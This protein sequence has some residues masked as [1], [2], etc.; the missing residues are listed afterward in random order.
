MPDGLPLQMGATGSDIWGWPPASAPPLLQWAAPTP[1]FHAPH[2][3]PH[4]HHHH[5]APLLLQSGDEAVDEEDAVSAEWLCTV[6]TGLLHDARYLHVL[7]TRRAPLRR[8]CLCYST[9]THTHTHTTFTGVHLQEASLEWRRLHCRCR[10]WTILT[11]PCYLVGCWARLRRGGIWTKLTTGY[12]FVAVNPLSLSSSL[13]RS[14]RRR[15]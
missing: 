6:L 3:H 7:C 15:R 13:M 10:N 12:M 4:H 8:E 11:Q 5:H 14:S 2:P 1:G 9:H